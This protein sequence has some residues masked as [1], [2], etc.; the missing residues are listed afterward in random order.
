MS[1]NRDRR[2]RQTELLRLI[3]EGEFERQDELARALEAK[4]FEVSQSAVSRDIKDLGVTKVAGR[5]RV[6]RGNVLHE[7]AA[8]VLSLVR[9]FRR[10]GEHLLVIH[11]NAGAAGVVAAEID[12]WSLP[13]I[14]GTIAG[15]DTVFVAVESLNGLEVVRARLAQ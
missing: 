15:D 11:T 2:Q 4:G 13:Q 7:P 8:S 14:A 10:A 6:V 9:G 1:V 3:S 12:S 5:Y